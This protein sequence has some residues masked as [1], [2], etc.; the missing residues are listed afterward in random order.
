MPVGTVL[1][2]IGGEGAV[3]IR[4][5]LIHGFER[6]GTSL[7][8]RTVA[9][10]ARHVIS[11][12]GLKKLAFAICGEKHGNWSTDRTI[13]FFA[14]ELLFSSRTPHDGRLDLVV[15]QAGL[16][17]AEF[18][19]FC[20]MWG[21]PERKLF[22]LREPRHAIES[23]RRKFPHVSLIDH[24]ERYCRQANVLTEVGGDVFTYSPSVRAEDYVSFLSPLS[25][26]PPELSFSAR[27]GLDDLPVCVHE[28]FSKMHRY[29]AE[30]A[31]AID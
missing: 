19:L 12:W 4:W 15:K 28:A 6:S 8:L 26:E 22:C 2:Q 29:S 31:S 24:C 18:E 16:Q 17:V 27:R 3:P 11:D 13:Q 23:A 30:S 21:K 20:R 5:W 7:M 10:Q 9:K 14:R 1:E 25:V